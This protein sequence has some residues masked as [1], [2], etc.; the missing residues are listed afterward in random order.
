MGRR[1]TPRPK[2]TTIRLPYIKEYVDRTGVV[3]RYFRRNRRT[4]GVLPGKP[5]SDEFMQAYQAFLGS[6]A[7]K[8]ARAGSGTIGALITSYYASSDFKNLSDNSKAL[9]SKSVLEPFA[10]KHGARLVRDI[11]KAKLVSYIEDIGQDR[12]GLANL[13]RAVISKLMQ[14]AIATDQRRDNPLAGLKP[15]KIGTW[16]T[17][18]DDELKAYE[19]RWP[20]GTPQRLAYAAMLYTGQRGGDVAGILLRD[21]LAGVIP[22]KQQKT[23][24][25]LHIEVHPELRRTIKAGPTKG[26]R[27]LGNANGE[28]LTQWA[29]WNLITRAAKDAGLPKRCIPHGLRKAMMRRLAE[30]GATGKEIQAVSGHKT[31]KEVERY[32]AAADQ[33]KLGKSAL[34]TLKPF[35]KRTPRV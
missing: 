3:R 29:L 17:W 18:T 10:E 23:G 35:K 28:P 22:F 15:Y 19:A 16:H 33:R 30:G 31:L 32:T 1:L 5:G 13:T 20:L 6:E 21:A 4:F 2:V 34:A 7:P 12:P 27:L 9:Y 11:V 24:T 26:V 8:T 25:E 14:Y